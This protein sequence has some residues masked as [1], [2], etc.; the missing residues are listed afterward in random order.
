VALNRYSQFSVT[1]S[2]G[3]VPASSGLPYADFMYTGGVQW[4]IVS[5]EEVG[6]LDLIAWKWFGDFSFWYYIALFNGII[7]PIGDV[8]SGAEIAIPVDAKASLPIIKP[9][10]YLQST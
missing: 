2:P 8:I 7:D 6:R 3:G 4:H 10:T 9:F 1:I 5:N